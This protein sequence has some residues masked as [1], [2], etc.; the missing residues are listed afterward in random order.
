MPVIEI[1]VTP[2]RGDCL[3]VHGIARDLAAAGLG[4]LKPL[5]G[6]Q[7][8]GQLREP[9]QVDA[10]LRGQARQPLPH[11]RRPAFPRREERPLARL[12]AAP[13]E[14]DRPAADLGSGRHHQLRD[15]RSQPAAARVRRRRS[16]A[17]I[18]SCARR[19]R[20]SRS[21][22]S[23]ARPTT[24]DAAISVIADSKG[25]HGIGGIMGGEDTG[26]QRR[27]HR[28]VPRG[29]LL[30]AD[31]H[32]RLRPQ[33]RHP[34]R[35]ALPLRARHRSAIGVWGAEVATRLILELCG[36][37]ASEIVPQRRDAR[38]GAQ[39]RPAR[40]PRED[41]DRRST[42][43]PAE[44]A[45]ILGKLGFGVERRRARGRPPCRPGAPTSWARPIWWRK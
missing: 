2:N 39:L 24:L 18:W 36:G 30:H 19:A 32:R 4:T 21:W 38:L 11:R 42:C 16:S 23:T 34:V 6:R 5:E 41:A 7:D 26:V 43:R 28:G 25:V 9:D 8:R 33:A 15:L 17:A 40:R 10:R 31:R 45:D 20:A 22:R 1:K 12:A 14:G 13:A 35:R 37:E 27:H 3:G 29:R 44:T